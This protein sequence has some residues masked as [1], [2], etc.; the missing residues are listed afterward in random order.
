[1][2]SIHPGWHFGFNIPAF[3]IVMLITVVLVRGIRESAEANNIMVL[4]KI[5][6]ILAFISF[7]A[8]F[9]KP[10]HYH[11]YYP[12][13]WSGLLTGGS[14]IFFT[15]IGFDSVSTAAEECSSPQRD[16]PIGIIATLIVCT[17]A[18]C[19]GRGGADRAGAVAVDGRRCRSGGQRAQEAFASTR[20]R[21][22]CTGCGWWCCL[23]RC[24][25]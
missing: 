24:W 9:I 16:L 13:G 25:G 23:A 3:L 10:T 1:M 7:G 20:R 21:T 22:A 6:A 11:P 2:S 15:Y 14:I 8:H 4:L 17:R 5:V 18:L 12:N 19:R